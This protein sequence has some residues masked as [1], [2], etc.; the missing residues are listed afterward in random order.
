MIWIA[1][2]EKDALAET[3]EQRFLATSL[4]IEP[5]DFDHA[6]FSQRGG[7]GNAHQP[8]TLRRATPL[9]SGRIEP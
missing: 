4:S 2:S 5:D 9:D 7:L 8:S 3:L 6:P 1:P